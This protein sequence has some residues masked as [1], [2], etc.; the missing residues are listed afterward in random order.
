MV[1]YLNVVF[2]L[3]ASIGGRRGK[4]LF[5]RQPHTIVVTAFR[6]GSRDTFVK[7]AAPT[8]KIVSQN[9]RGQSIQL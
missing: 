9:Q 1:K 5:K 7:V 3:T 4:A 8:I 2:Y 6:N